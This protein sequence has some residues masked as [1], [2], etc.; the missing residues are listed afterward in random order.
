MDWASLFNG[1]CGACGLGLP[2]LWL[3]GIARPDQCMRGVH[4]LLAALA[5][6]VWRTATRP[7]FPV[8]G[9]KPPRVHLAD[10]YRVI[11]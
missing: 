11:R 4:R 3:L 9:P 2:L 6:A 5:Q 10:V 8:M 1:L 7:A